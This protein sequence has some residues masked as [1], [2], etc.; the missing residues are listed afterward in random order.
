MSNNLELLKQINQ[1]LFNPQ[2]ALL[3]SSLP[4][5][6]RDMGD[7]WMRG[8]LATVKDDPKLMQAAM[9]NGPAFVAA[10]QKA[11]SLGLAPG[12]DEFYLVPFGK[13][14]NAVTG[15]KGLI[16]LIY[17]AGRVES[18]VSYVVYEHDKWAFTYGVDE[19]PKFQ[20]APD[21]QRGNRS[22]AVAFARFKNGR[23]SNVARVGKD[24]IQEA[25]RASGNPNTDRPSPVWEKHPDAMWRKTAL[26]ELST[27]VDTSVEECR[28]EKLAA[29]ADRRKAEVARMDAETRRLEAEN[30]AMEL[31][32]RLAEIEAARG[33]QVDVSTGELVG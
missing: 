7:E 24:R 31:K 12:T 21:G 22:F 4:S 26:R 33:D 27:W 29:I 3:V 16:E 20:P 30:R 8:V 32:L 5:H 9:N 23:I 1:S 10:I 6:M 25:M 18:I 28:P 2:K 14:I 11:A 19:E 17:R 13:Q 15:Y